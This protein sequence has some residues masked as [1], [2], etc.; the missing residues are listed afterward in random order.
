M[1]ARGLT[2][3]TILNIGLTDKK[4][5]MFQIGDAVEVAQNIK[6]G[7]KERVQLFEGDVIGMHNNG[8]ASTFTVRRICS[9]GVG[10]EKIFPFHSPTIASIRLTKYGKARRAKLY[11]LRERLGKAARVAERVLTKEQKAAAK[12]QVA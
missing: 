4:Y 10:V 9:N 3:E 5:P 6:D 8:V 12:A 11:Y 1:K 2:R 7:D